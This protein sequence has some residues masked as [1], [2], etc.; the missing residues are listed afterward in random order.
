MFVMTLRHIGF[1]G[2]VALGEDAQ[3]LVII[4]GLRAVAVKLAWFE[5]DLASL[6]QFN[7]FGRSKNAVLEYGVNGLHCPIL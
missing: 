1:T 4:P 2:I 7:G 6:G 3:D 5:F